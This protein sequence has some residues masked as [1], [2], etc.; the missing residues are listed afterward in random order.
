MKERAHR[1]FTFFFTQLGGSIQNLMGLHLAAIV[2][3]AATLASAAAVAT[4]R[5]SAAG[6]RSLPAIVLSYA[7]A[8]GFVV[9]LAA[10]PFAASR[11]SAALLGKR[12]RDGS[13]P[14]WSLVAF[15]PFHVGLRTKLAFQRATGTESNYDEVAPFTGGKGARKANGGGGRGRG[16]ALWRRKNEVGAEDANEDETSPIPYYLG[17]WPHGIDA[18][19]PGVSA[20]V[21]VTAELPRIAPAERYLNLRVWDTHGASPLQIEAA[22]RWIGER[23]RE[24]RKVISHCAHGHGRSVTVLAAALLAEREEEEDGSTCSSSSSSSSEEIDAVLAHIQKFRP[25]AKLNSRQRRA[26]EGWL[27]LRRARKAS[28]K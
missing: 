13:L 4:A 19:P 18:L 8:T 9:A 17:G 27:E 12:E 23:R 1:A 14:L 2:S 6:W 16:Q 7:S 21:D 22:V 11:G 10:T 5:S 24:G 26:L 3:G 20:V 25:R 28:V 15:A